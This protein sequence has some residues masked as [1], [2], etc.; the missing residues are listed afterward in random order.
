[1]I[2]GRSG[3]S[4]G[5]RATMAL[6][7]AAS[8]G[9]SPPTPGPT[10]VECEPAMEYGDVSTLVSVR[11]PLE[12]TQPIRMDATEVTQGQYQRF[13]EATNGGMEPTCQ[14]DVAPVPR[15]SQSSFVGFRCCAGPE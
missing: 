5:L 9:C 3:G 8:L 12:P 6:A 2:K 10:P 4:W 1:M 15:S 14:R 7:V 13:L 11:N